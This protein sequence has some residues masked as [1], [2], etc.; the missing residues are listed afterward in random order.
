MPIITSS[1]S[2]Q[3]AL[4]ASGA[5][6]SISGKGITVFSRDGFSG[7]GQMAQDDDWLRSS[8]RVKPNE[9]ACIRSFLVLKIW[10]IEKALASRANRI[11]CISKSGEGCT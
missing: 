6:P 8:L 7:S 2:H 1:S 3:P 11:Q 5:E 10:S 4:H 9:L